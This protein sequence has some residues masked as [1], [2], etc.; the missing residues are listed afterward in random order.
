MKV[1]GTIFFLTATRVYRIFL[2]TSLDENSKAVRC[3]VNNLLRCLLKDKKHLTANAL[4]LPRA[5]IRLQL[6][7]FQYKYAI[8]SLQG[9][10][11]FIIL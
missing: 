10:C 6:N 3:S 4:Y 2:A 8:I 9:N 1:K 11:K 5:C 7:C